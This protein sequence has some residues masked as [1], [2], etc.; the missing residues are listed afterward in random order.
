M[1]WILEQPDRACVE[2]LQREDHLSPLFAVL[3]ANRGVTT[4]ADAHRYLSPSPADLFDPLLLPDV[5]VAAERLHRAVRQGERVMLFGDYDVDG[6]SAISIYQELCTAL[7]LTPVVRLPQRLSEGY[8]LSRTVIMEAKTAGI[9][10]LITA[11]CG[12]TA[13][14]EIALA[15]AEGIDVIVTDH[16]QVPRELPAAVATINPWRADSV[17]PFR[18]LC[19]AGLAWKV[20]SAV[21]LQP[22]GRMIEPLLEEWT[23]LAALGTVADVM[24]LRGEN[25]YLVA[26]GL[27][28]LSAGRRVGVRALKRVAGIEGKPV[29][30]GAIGFVLAP[31][32]NAAGRLGDAR[33][34]VELLTTTDEAEAA[35]LAD[36]HQRENLARRQIEESVLQAALAAVDAQAG[37]DEA[38]ALVVAGRGW[39]PG[40]IG[41]I[42]ARLVDRH[43]RPAVV[44]AIDEATG[45]GKGSGRTIPGVDLYEALSHCAPQLIQFGGHRMAAG[46]TIRAEQVDAFRTALAVAVSRQVEATT[47]EPALTIDAEINL[48]DCTWALIEEINRMAPFGPGNREP[49]FVTR[50]ALPSEIRRLNGNHLRFVLRHDMVTA[51][52][53]AFGQGDRLDELVRR[54]GDPGV[55]VGS[56]G[57]RRLI[58][59]VFTLKEDRW[60]GERRL[61]LHVKDFAPTAQPVLA[62]LDLGQPLGV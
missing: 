16:H 36:H 61:Q 57:E 29:G 52:A 41:I 8:G 55:P 23:D 45:I 48:A 20:A 12:T 3:L 38:P 50:A 44:I 5:G 10:L 32:L 31:R 28:R 46:L 6:I 43:Y 62:R 47:F 1:R 21:A 51:S 59:V 2:Q 18:G 60:Q 54:S 34:G 11:D 35:R 17:Y 26:A 49:V 19:S 27:R 24:P 15:R 39:H 9:S 22:W 14:E 33:S 56:G 7:G 13:I 4:P 40:V 42:A 25:R 58:D 37:R 30:V 53:I